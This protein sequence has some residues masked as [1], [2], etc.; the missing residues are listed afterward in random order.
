MKM[1]SVKQTAEIDAKRGRTIG[2]GRGDWFRSPSLQTGQADLPHPAFQLVVLP[3]LGLTSRDMGG[4]KGKQPTLDK[5]GI[6]ASLHSLFKSC[7]HPQRPDDRLRPGPS[8]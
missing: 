7:Q 1:K 2:V 5:E 8:A 6:F 4:D 3:G